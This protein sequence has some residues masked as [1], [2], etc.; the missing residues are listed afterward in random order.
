MVI[1]MN[2]EQQ[3]ELITQVSHWIRLISKNIKS[4]TIETEDG[5][6]TTFQITKKDVKDI[7]GEPMFKEE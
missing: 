2:M 5:S 4:V 1:K 3:K 7:I 6:V